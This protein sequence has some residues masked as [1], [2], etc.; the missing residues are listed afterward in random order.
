MAKYFP[1]SSFVLNDQ[2][3][4]TTSNK[5]VD[6][7]KNDEQILILTSVSDEEVVKRYNE[8]FDVCINNKKEVEN[9]II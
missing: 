5:V 8:L 6:L 1:N 3:L 2:V 4:Y 9:L 7:M